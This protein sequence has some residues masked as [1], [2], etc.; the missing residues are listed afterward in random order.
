MFGTGGRGA[1][2]QCDLPRLRQRTTTLPRMSEGCTVQTY[3]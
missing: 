3:R 1:P 2:L